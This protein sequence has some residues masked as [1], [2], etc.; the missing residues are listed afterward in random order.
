MRCV[1]DAEAAKELAKEED[2]EGRTWLRR[3]QVRDAIK[4]EHRLSISD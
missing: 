1:S 4:H 3:Y 2:A